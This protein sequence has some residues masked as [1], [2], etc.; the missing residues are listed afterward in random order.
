[1]TRENSST[2]TL[3]IMLT[4]LLQVVL[5]FADTK[6]APHRAV[7]AFAKCYFQLDPR[8]ETLV[9]NKIA[10]DAEDNAIVAYLREAEHHARERGFEPSFL[11]KT[12]YDIRTVTLQSDS[13]KATVHITA[14]MKRGI[15]PVFAYVGK[16]FFLG[17]TYHLDRTVDV[18]FEGG[19]WKVCSGFFDLAD[20][21]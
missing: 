6:D 12:L 18:V 19:K 14:E 9:C 7:T 8:M 13:Q 4:V 20:L 2:I 15:N 10:G 1:M 5:V 17:N 16:I 11:K 21:G 3:L